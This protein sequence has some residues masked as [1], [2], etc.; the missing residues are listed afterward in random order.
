MNYTYDSLDRLLEWKI[1]SVVAETYGYDASTG[2][3]EYK[4]SPSLKLDYGDQ[5]QV[6]AATSYNGWLYDYDAIGNMITR[7][8]RPAW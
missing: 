1:N 8:S 5:D 7:T 6:H 2:N 3:L 4:G